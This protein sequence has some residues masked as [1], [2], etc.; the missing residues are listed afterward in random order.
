MDRE[1]VFVEDVEVVEVA[2]EQRKTSEW[3]IFEECIDNQDLRIPFQM[4]LALRKFE[5]NPDKVTDL[6]QKINKKYGSKGLHIAQFVQNGFFG[7]YLANILEQTPTT[8]ELKSQILNLFNDIENKV[9]FVKNQDAVDKKTKN[10]EAVNKKVDQIVTKINAN[11]PKTYI[12][13]ATY[14][15]MGLCEEIVNQVMK[16]ID[17]YKAEF[18]KTEIKI[19]Y[20]LNKTD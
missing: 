3:K 19:I 11:N 16:R 10:R 6:R 8:Q 12:V 7:K 9:T 18:S 4:G 13:C 14:S 20:F 17:G 1:L 2:K 5:N 15:A